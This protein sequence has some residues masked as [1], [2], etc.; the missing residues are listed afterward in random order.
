MSGFTSLENNHRAVA[1]LE[2]AIDGDGVRMR[3][4]TKR[5]NPVLQ[6]TLN[7]DRIKNCGRAVVCGEYVMVWHTCLPNGLGTGEG[8]ARKSTRSNLLPGLAGVGLPWGI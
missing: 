2:H 6:F 8:F 4:V 5:G 1:A 3:G 7:G